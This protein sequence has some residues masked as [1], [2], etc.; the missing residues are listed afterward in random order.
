VLP[1]QGYHGA[2]MVEYGQLGEIVI[3]KGKFKKLGEKSAQLP[4]CPP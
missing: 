4:L 1:G 2:V 3:N